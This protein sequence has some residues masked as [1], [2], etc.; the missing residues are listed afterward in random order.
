MRFEKKR[1]WVITGGAQGIGKCL[2]DFL[3]KQNQ[4]VYYLDTHP[5]KDEIIKNKK[6]QEL[7]FIPC[8]LSKKEDMDNVSS[9]LEKNNTKV[10]V[11]IHNA[12]I[13]K[14]GLNDASY[15]DFL[16]VQK[17]N[18]VAPFYLSKKFMPLF[19]E[20]ASII[21]IASTRAFQSQKNTEAYT[22]S[23]GGIISLTHT[24]SM[25]LEG[26]VRVNS[27]SPGWIDTSSCDVNRLS[28]AFEDHQ[29]HPSK[30]IGAPIDIFKAVSFLSDPENDFINGENIIID[31]GMTKKM[32][33]HQDEQWMYHLKKDK[34]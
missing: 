24:M 1:V 11:L 6:S 21:L 16:E 25:T 3:L 13:S 18:L 14:G 28:F 20:K 27:V 32:I 7:I 26:K 15:D 23:K 5:A 34:E 31:G 8:D 29:Q 4:R 30:R 19:N 12:A 22:A 2:V 33:Y 10:D 9:T 17:V